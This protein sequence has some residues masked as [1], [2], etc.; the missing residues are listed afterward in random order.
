MGC[1]LTIDYQLISIHHE[2]EK[3]N[4]NWILRTDSNHVPPNI[5][6][7]YGRTYTDL[8]TQDLSTIPARMGCFLTIDYQLISIHH[9]EEKRK[10]NWM[11]RTDS[12]HVPP[13]I[14][15]LYGRTYTDLSAQDF[16]GDLVRKCFQTNYNYLISIHH[17]EERKNAK[18]DVED[19]FKPCFSN[20]NLLYHR[21]YPDLYPEDFLEDL[22][23]M[24]CFLTNY[25]HLI[26]IHHKEQ[27]RKQ[28][29]ML[30]TDSNHVPPNISLLYR[31]TYTDL[32]A[33]DLLEDLARMGCFL[34]NYYPLKSKHHKEQNRKQK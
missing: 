14:N 34:T 23:R 1:F 3:R 33:Q 16:L 10:Q 24:G 6:L 4:Q 29:W 22:A 18:M 13:N 15:L 27:N 20:I 11:L 25:Y 5:N 30:R 28:K 21:T 12:N 17:E 2:E 9:E 7:L 32:S 19:R 8:S 26:S 31:R